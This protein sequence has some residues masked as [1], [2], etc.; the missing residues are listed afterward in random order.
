[1]DFCTEMGG[2]WDIYGVQQDFLPGWTSKV[3]IEGLLF[4]FLQICGV[5]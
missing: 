5:W 3:K 2:D 1:M 4:M